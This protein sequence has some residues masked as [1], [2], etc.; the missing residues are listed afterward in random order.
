MTREHIVQFG[1]CIDDDAIAKGV[2]QSAEKEVIK[3]ICEKVEDVIYAKY[4]YSYSR[5]NKDDLSPLRYIVEHKVDE[6]INE[7]KQFILD[8]AS[9]I[10]A[11]KLARSKAG[12]AILENLKT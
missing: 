8:N 4:G 1:V 7:N 5:V 2:Q 10:L 3:M 9:K 6:V 12:K 11:D